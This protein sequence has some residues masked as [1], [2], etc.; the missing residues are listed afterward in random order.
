MFKRLLYILFAISLAGCTIPGLSPAPSSTPAAVAASNPLIVIAPPG[1]TATA[2]PFLP[3]GPTATYLPTD[4][5]TLTPTLTPTP[6]IT[7]TPTPTATPVNPWGS[8]AGPTV[9]PDITIPA[10]MGILPQPEGQINLLLLG[11]DKRPY[12]GGY[13]TDTILLV[14]INSDLGTVN[15]TSFPR[16]LYVYIPGWTVQRINTA[17]VHGGFNLLAE[18]ME[19]NFGVRPTHY[20]I[21]THES[22][23]QVVDS[24]GGI[25]VQVGRT[26]SDQREGYEY[27]TVYAGSNYFDG[28]TALWYVRSRYSSSDFDRNR[29]QQEVI[30]GIA[31]RFLRFDIITKA[32]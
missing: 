15:I 5:P 18:T 24:L 30:K 3:V 4:F 27:Y 6:T 32:P 2:T 26:L 16:D 20:A 14:T 7:P 25:D 28:E 13:R 29:R 10:P 9:W 31:M 23:K 21:I 11:S 8:Y 12:E 17:M 19:Y 1:S 22:F